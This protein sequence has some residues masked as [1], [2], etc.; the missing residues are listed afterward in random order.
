MASLTSSVWARATAIGLLLGLATA[1]AMAGGAAASGSKSSLPA[2]LKGMK[3]MQVR[4]V[5]SAASGCE[6]DC[7]EWISAEGDI[8][9]ATPAAFEQVFRKLGKRRL[10]VL[11]HSGGG[12]VNQLVARLRS[13]LVDSDGGSFL[14]LRGVQLI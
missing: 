3:P 1:L 6:P 10:P 11:I 5:R 7:A 14:V 12:S 8:V 13:Y 9:D 4:I 2:L